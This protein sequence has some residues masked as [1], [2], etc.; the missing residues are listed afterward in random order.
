MIATGNQ[1]SVRDFVELCIN[2]LDIEIE[3]QGEGIEERAIIKESS[4]IYPNLSKGREIVKVSSNYF[5]PAEVETLLGDPSKALKDL[6]WSPKI[7]AKDLVDDMM[8]SDLDEAKKLSLLKD[9]DYEFNK[10]FE[11]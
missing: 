10:G 2:F 6:G 5:R 8:K 7:T 11:I 9:H 3:W 4:S 1:I